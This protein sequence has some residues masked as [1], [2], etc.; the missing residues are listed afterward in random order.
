[1]YKMSNVCTQIGSP[2]AQTRIDIKPLSQSS[3]F[4]NSLK[5]TNKHYI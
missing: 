4:N 3:I 5:R 2:S 1:M